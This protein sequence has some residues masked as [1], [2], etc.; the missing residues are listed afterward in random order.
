MSNNI[1]NKIIHRGLLLDKKGNVSALCF[2]RPKA[3]SLKKASWTI[4]N[5]AVTCKKC[6]ALLEGVI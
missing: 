1:K 3:I 4:R 6:L 2:K 5:E